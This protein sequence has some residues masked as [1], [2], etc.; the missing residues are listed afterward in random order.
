MTVAEGDQKS[1]TCWSH[2]SPGAHIAGTGAI[3]ATSAIRPTKG[4]DHA[5]YLHYLH[6]REA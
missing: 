3:R 2:A 5:R 4:S 1:Q 6:Q